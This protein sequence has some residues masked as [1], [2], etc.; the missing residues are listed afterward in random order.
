MFHYFHVLGHVH[1]L[2]STSSGAHVDV[3]LVGHSLE[4]VAVLGDVNATPATPSVA[5]RSSTARSSISSASS[6]ST[7]RF[8]SVLP[9]SGEVDDHH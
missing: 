8:L 3:T 1:L 9:G 4:D 6:S 5:S 2:V 7:S